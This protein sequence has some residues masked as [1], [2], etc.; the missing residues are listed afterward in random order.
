[1]VSRDFELGRVVGRIELL[2]E[3]LSE[4]NKAYEKHVSMYLE[5]EKVLNE[6]EY[7][8]NRP[9][10][11]REMALLIGLSLLFAGLVVALVAVPK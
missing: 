4:H 3:R 6:L 8:I 2:L 5:A 10:T 7:N 9:M 1:M 11:W